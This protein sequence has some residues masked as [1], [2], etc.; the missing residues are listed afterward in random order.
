MM[1][2][3][4]NQFTD[5]Q[6]DEWVNGGKFKTTG[7]RLLTEGEKDWKTKDWPRFAEIEGESQEDRTKRLFSS[8]Q[9]LVGNNIPCGYDSEGYPSNDCYCEKHE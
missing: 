8:P 1:S 9:V 7:I 5:K 2:T 4:F 3:D 6:K